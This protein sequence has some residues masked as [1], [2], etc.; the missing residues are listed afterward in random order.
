[1]AYVW[2]S[3]CFIGVLF[4]LL[5]C[6]AWLHLAYNKKNNSQTRQ[7]HPPSEHNRIIHHSIKYHHFF[8]MV[9]TFNDESTMPTSSSTQKPIKNL[10]LNMKPFNNVPSSD[11]KSTAVSTVTSEGFVH[12]CWKVEPFP[13]SNCLKGPRCNIARV[14]GGFLHR[15][16]PRYADFGSWKVVRPKH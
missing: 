10:C 4:L 16:L 6:C 14:P 11:I 2:L 13:I 3:I 1:M 7:S 5:A 12:L 8:C 15:A 9:Y